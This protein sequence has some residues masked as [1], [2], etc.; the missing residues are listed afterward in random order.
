MAP[1]RLHA[2]L[3]DMDGT[4]VDSDAAVDR[5][6]LTWSAEYGVDP[7]RATA[8]A[9]GRP[10]SETIRELLPELDPEALA[11]ATARMRDLECNDLS[12]VVATEGAHELLAYV[13]QL[14]LPWAVV[15]SASARLAK[16]RLDAAGIAPSVLVTSDDVPRGK[17]DP[18]GYLLAAELLGV[19]AGACL[20]VEDAEVGAAAGRA[21]GARVA[22]LKGVAGDLPVAGLRDLLPVLG[23]ENGSIPAAA[24]P[25]A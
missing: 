13:E 17:P 24:D 12:D 5:S 8:L 3:F 19:S 9:P 16:A 20:V 2:L 21:A 4:L 14:G 25:A 22:T 1:T 7:R 18:A 15:T 23:N 10:D 11:V 6:W